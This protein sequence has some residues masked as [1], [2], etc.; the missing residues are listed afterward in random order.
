MDRDVPRL[1]WPFVRFQRLGLSE[2]IPKVVVG[3][4]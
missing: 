1:E 3:Q 2:E 4:F